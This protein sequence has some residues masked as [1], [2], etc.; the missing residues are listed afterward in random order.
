MSVGECYSKSDIVWRGKERVKKVEWCLK[1]RLHPTNVH[2]CCV[3]GRSEFIIYSEKSA[4]WTWNRQNM[5]WNSEEKRSKTWPFHVL[6]IIITA[7]ICFVF[8]FLSDYKN[9]EEWEIMKFVNF[10]GNAFW[11]GTEKNSCFER[12]TQ[13]KI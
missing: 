5:I 10:S 12:E 9:G 3:V 7:N 13:Q 1:L 8:G 6:F 4:N 2:S 11:K